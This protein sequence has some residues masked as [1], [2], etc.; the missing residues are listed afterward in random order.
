V[1]SEW[2]FSS[3]ICNSDPPEKS[4]KQKYI[5]GISPRN[6]NKSNIPQKVLFMQDDAAT[7]EDSLHT[8]PQQVQGLIGSLNTQYLFMAN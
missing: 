4:Q 6:Y 7:R 3:S 8:A 2:Y 1:A 5:A